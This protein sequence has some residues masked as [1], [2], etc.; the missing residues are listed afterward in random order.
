MER[1]Q[2]LVQEPFGEPTGGFGSAAADYRRNGY[3]LLEGLMPRQVT[4]AIYNRLGADLDLAR[5]AQKYTVQGALLSKPAIEV[6]S[7]IY[8]PLATLLWGLTPVATALAG[9]RL[10]PTYAYF[11]AYQ[12][13]DVCRVHGDRLACEHSM[14]LTLLLGEEKPWALTV[15]RERREGPVS[16][17]D[18]DYGG[19]EFAEL[20][21]G[22]GDA[23]MYQGVNHRHGRLQPNPNSWSAHLFL[24]WVDADGPH[25]DQAFD[26][27]ALKANGMAGQA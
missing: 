6:Y 21:M 10:L 1:Q 3:A 9:K 18:E 16:A 15:E 27:P 5:S 26:R 20:P 13:G 17:V 2:G 19:G 23:V 12:Q 22:S 8:P 24:H 25:A 11:R 14:S 7:H 4:T